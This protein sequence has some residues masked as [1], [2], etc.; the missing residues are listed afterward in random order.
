MAGAV[1]VAAYFRRRI[2]HHEGIVG[3]TI[4][5][6]RR[7]TRPVR[8]AGLDEIQPVAGGEIRDPLVVGGHQ[9][10]KRMQIV[11][12]VQ[13]FAGMKGAG[14]LARSA[15]EPSF[16]GQRRPFEAEAED[17]R[18]SGFAMRFEPCPCRVDDGQVTTQRPRASPIEFPAA[19]GIVAEG[20]C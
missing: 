13:D 11:E 3:P 12:D 16:G 18:T 9:P 1:G 14:F 4:G 19:A 5:W 2:D 6:P 17:R 7:K 10:G 15:L 8:I 20:L